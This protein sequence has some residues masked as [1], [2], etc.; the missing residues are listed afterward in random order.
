MPRNRKICS[1]P[2]TSA[3]W[4]SRHWHICITIGIGIDIGIDIPKSLFLPLWIV[5]WKNRTFMSYTPHFFFLCDVIWHQYHFA[6]LLISLQFPVHPSK[7][8]HWYSK[9]ILFGF[10][11]SPIHLCF[12]KALKS[13]SENFRKL[14][15]KIS[16]VE[17]LCAVAGLPGSFAKRC[18]KLFC[19]KP[20]SAWFCKKE[21]QVTLLFR[22]F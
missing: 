17:S 8:V 22:N 12:E 7:D 1:K 3:I 16:I 4:K 13:F 18:V 2:Y 10:S 14:P 19:R 9:K 21:P 20:V 11:L 15:S 6:S 5:F